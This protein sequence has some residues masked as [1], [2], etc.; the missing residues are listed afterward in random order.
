MNPRYECKRRRGKQS[1]RWRDEI[2]WLAGNKW[3][4][5]TKDRVAWYKKSKT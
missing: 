3:L 4:A 1:K 2:K 5:T